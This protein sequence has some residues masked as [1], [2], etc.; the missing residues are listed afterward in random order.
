MPATDSPVVA[1]MKA[2][3]AVI[4][5]KTNVPVLSHTGSH[6]NDSW[7]GPTYN[8]VGREFLPGGSS[9]GTATAVAASMAV[10]GLAEETGRIDPEP[11]LGARPGRHQADFC[12]GAQRRRDA[13][14][15]Q[16]RRRG[17]DRALRE[18]RGALPRRPGWLHRRGSQDRLRGLAIGPLAAMRRSSTPTR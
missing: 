3:G 7:A 15:L 1:R 5:G 2:A 13:A 4:L 8:A 17:P 6:A 16:P 11:G 18:R 10:L 14:L 9:A 12:A